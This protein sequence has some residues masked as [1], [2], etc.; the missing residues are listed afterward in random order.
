ML[1]IISSETGMNF[2]PAVVPLVWA[3]RVTS[4]GHST[5]RSPP[6]RMRA[7]SSLNAYQSAIGVTF[8]YAP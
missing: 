1:R 2:S 5:P 4:P 6:S 3:K 7:M 8:V